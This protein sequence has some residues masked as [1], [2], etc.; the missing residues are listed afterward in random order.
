MANLFEPEFDESQDQPGFRHR[1][2]KLG[3]QAG[4]ERLGASVYELPPGEAAFPMHYHLGNEELLIALAG[5]PTLR[6]PDGERELEEGEAVA[7]PV[8]ERGAH[9]IVNRGEEPARV[10]IVSEMIAPEI[11]VRPESG[12]LSAFGRPPGSRGEG[13]HGVFFERDS[14]PFWEGEEPPPR[15]DE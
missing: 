12:K 15:P 11:V 7:F 14:V 3:E 2:A 5:R 4:S 10:L 1:R 8:G 6:T 9:Q 13:M